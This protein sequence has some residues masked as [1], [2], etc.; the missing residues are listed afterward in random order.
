MIR[1]GRRDQPYVEAARSG[2]TRHGLRRLRKEFAADRDPVGHAV[3]EHRAGEDGVAHARARRMKIPRSTVGRPTAPTLLNPQRQIRA[4]RALPERT[5]PGRDRDRRIECHLRAPVALLHEAHLHAEL[6]VTVAE[7]FRTRRRARK[8]Y[9]SRQR[10]LDVGHE[11]VVQFERGHRAG[12]G[13]RPV[14]V[15][16]EEIHLPLTVA[17]RLGVVGLERRSGDRRRRERSEERESADGPAA[18][19]HRLLMRVRLVL[20]AAYAVSTNGPSR[21]SSPLRRQNSATPIRT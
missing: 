20:S 3:Q 2:R 6:R 10:D 8:P 4:E 12:R 15:V 18:G 17:R 9:R 21:A 14:G 16:A 19:E 7:L 1:A 11:S 13:G 5:L